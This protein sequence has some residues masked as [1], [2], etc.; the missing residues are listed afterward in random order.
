MFKYPVSIA[1]FE[2]SNTKINVGGIGGL[3]MYSLDATKSIV[4]FVNSSLSS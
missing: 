1:G 4:P 2:T 3:F